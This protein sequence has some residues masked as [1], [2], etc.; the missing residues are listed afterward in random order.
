MKVFVDKRIE[1]IN[2]IL[3]LSDNDFKKQYSTMFEIN[4]YVEKIHRDFSKF[5]NHKILNLNCL[6]LGGRF[7]TINIA[8]FIDNNYVFPNNVFFRREGFN[9]IEKEFL[10][11]L[12][13]FAIEINFDEWFKSNQVFYDQICSD[14]CSLLDKGNFDEFLRF[15]YKNDYKNQKNEYAVVLMPSLTNCGYYRKLNGNSGITILCKGARSYNGKQ[16]TFA[17]DDEIRELNFTTM[18]HEFSHGIIDNAV[19]K[20]FEKNEFFNIDTPISLNKGVYVGKPKF[21]DTIIEGIVQAYYDYA[22]I[23]ETTHKKRLDQWIRNGFDQIEFVYEQIKIYVKNINKYRC[24]SEYV[25]T[26]LTK[27]KEKVFHN[28]KVQN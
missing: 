13:Q 19:S 15:F 18:V 4:P 25:P 16:L 10:K 14:Y 9:N 21:Y 8:C 11:L 6:T 24:F 27:L 17:R 23:S 3:N 22:G 1:L 28:N 2:L 20:Y 12:P 7:D 5:K 26:I